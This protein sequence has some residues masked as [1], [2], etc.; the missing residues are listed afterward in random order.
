MDREQYYESKIGPDQRYTD[1][2]KDYQEH[3]KNHDKMMFPPVIFP[4]PPKMELQGSVSN[5][6]SAPPSKKSR[7]H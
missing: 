5:S 7:T 4:W 2:D 6:S 1:S 3:V